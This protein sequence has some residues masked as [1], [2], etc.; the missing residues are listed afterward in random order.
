MQVKLILVGGN[1]W[2]PLTGVLVVRRWTCWGVLEQSQSSEIDS[3]L[4]M[5]KRFP[6]SRLGD[7]EPLR[8]PEELQDPKVSWSESES[9]G[10]GG[11]SNTGDLLSPCSASRCLL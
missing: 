7:S 3:L 11:A 9:G 2:T 8:L 5:G 1:L 6:G 4:K 10:L